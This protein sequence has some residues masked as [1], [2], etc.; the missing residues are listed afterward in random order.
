M[1]ILI[2]TYFFPPDRAVGGQRALKV[3]TALKGAGHDVTII[4]QGDSPLRAE[5]G[6]YRVRSMPSAR[7]LYLSLRRSFLRDRARRSAHH[8]GPEPVS[9]EPV[10]FWKRWIISLLRLPDDKQGFIVPA[11]RRALKLRNGPPDLIYTTAP[12]FSVHL[13][14]LLLNVLTGT[15]W[16]AEFR[17]PWTANPWKPESM[18]SAMSDR[19]EMLMEELC[20]RRADLV[21]AVSDGIARGLE[22]TDRAGPLLTVRN[23]IQRLENPDGR[24]RTPGAGFEIVYAGS[25]YHQR[26][27]RPFLEA[28][29]TMAASGQARDLRVRFIGGTDSY[30]GR[31]IPVLI[32]ERHLTESV[33]CLDWMPTEECHRHLTS[34]DALLLLATG[35]PDQ[36]PNKLYEYLGTGRPILAIVDADGESARMLRLAGG[37]EIVTQNEPGA[38]AEGLARLMGQARERPAANL[39]LLRQWTTTKQ[40]ATLVAAI[41]RLDTARPAIADDG[42]RPGREALSKGGR[43]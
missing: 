33:E 7:G 18:R 1:K 23:G 12:P 15:P 38:I 40:M 3:A 25:F 4:A 30:D 37:H 32:R 39:Q 17:D 22:G 31:S 8:P 42:G 10:P 20:L 5:G 6:V 13:A 11:V 35:Q 2:V 41:H 29:E 36:V 28:I 43:A 9:V 21:V 27:P 26:D 34:A 14:G 24:S 16:I 19:A